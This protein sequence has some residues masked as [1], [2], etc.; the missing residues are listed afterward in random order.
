M[1]T[2]LMT[3]GK[4]YVTT[5][6]CM[7]VA[8]DPASGEQLWTFDPKAYDQPQGT[9][10][11]L[12]CRGVEY[13]TDG[14]QERIILATGGLQLFAIDPASGK[15]IDGFGGE[16]GWT[17]L[18][19]GLGREFKRSQFNI[20]A[21]VIVCRDTIVIGSIVNDFGNAKRMP[22]GH[23]RGRP[24]MAAAAALYFGLA[25]PEQGHAVANRLERDFLSPGGFVSTLIAS[26][27]QWDA[28]NGWPPLQ[29]LAVQGL[30][31][32]DREPL[33]ATVR[34]RWLALN[35][36]WFE[37]TGKM[38][39]KYDVVDL[40][41]KGGGGEYPTQDGFGWTNGVALVFAAQERAAATGSTL[42]APLVCAVASR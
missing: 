42:A 16:G 5:G 18:Y 38:T 21:P 9:H 25:T 4:L 28:P 11:G 8:L 32:Y 13:W 15:P 31:R 12:K 30:C 34:E 27:Q 26:D 17:D 24:T 2:P 10:G 33:A 23:V 37:E 7:L 29:W 22:P 39:E 6:L 40:N 14:K 35:R 41:R 20:S 19:P 36:R 1:P 3:G